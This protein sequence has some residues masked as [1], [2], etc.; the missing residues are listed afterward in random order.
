M[1]GKKKLF[2]AYRHK[3][4]NKIVSVY[5]YMFFLLLA[6]FRRLVPLRWLIHFHSLTRVSFF[7]FFFSSLENTTVKLMRRKE[8][9][10]ELSRKKKN[11]QCS[12]N[13][14]KCVHIKCIFAHLLFIVLPAFILAL[15]LWR[16]LRRKGGRW[17]V[18][19]P[20]PL[21]ILF[22]SYTKIHQVLCGCPYFVLHGALLFT[23]N[24][25]IKLASI[26]TS[27]HQ[28][29][30]KCMN[31]DSF[32]CEHKKHSWNKNKITGPHLIRQPCPLNEN[33]T[34][35]W[36]IKI[37]FFFEFCNDERRKRKSEKK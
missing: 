23:Y 11:Q 4:P 32:L 37:L 28:R 7:N 36:N 16:H 14:C 18:Y 34:Y 17:G 1:P 13:T 27:Y 5:V 2:C 25:T 22:F 19:F 30:T 3:P 8:E 10:R 15:F 9:K 21:L 6:K 29:T 12:I 24:T 20:V 26:T 35:A 31:M 33:E